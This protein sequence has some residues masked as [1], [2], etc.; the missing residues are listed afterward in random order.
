MD[1]SLSQKEGHQPEFTSERQSCARQLQ[2]Q[3]HSWYVYVQ[4]DSNGTGTHSSTYAPPLYRPNFFSSTY[5]SG[6]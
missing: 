6:G 4:N 1:N 2:A 5:L 3:V